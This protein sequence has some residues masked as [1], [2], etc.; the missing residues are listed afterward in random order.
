MEGHRLKTIVIA[1]L[2]VLNGFLLVLVGARKTE[3][4]RYE[5]SALERT[6][7]VLARNGIQTTEDAVMGRS[8]PSSVTAERD[9]AME[10]AVAAALLGEG[11]EGNNR[12]GGLYIYATERGQLSFRSGGE[13]AA[14]FSEDDFWRTDDPE[15]HA[16]QLMDSLK[17][18]CEQIRCDISEGSGQVVYRQ[19]LDGSPLY[20]CRLTFTYK[21]G[22][23]TALSGNLLATEAEKAENE[24]LLS[25]PTVLM[26]FLDDVLES[27]DVCSAILKVEPGYL[28]VQSFTEAMRLNPVWYISTNT[29]DY[30][31]DA[32][33]GQ[34]TRVTE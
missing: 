6:I 7:E 23:L 11:A 29:A 3:A 12:G 9:L 20:S 34:L 33:T 2:L 4:V 19:L 22:R 17:L 24:E 8:V 18:D 5:Q 21:Q 15:S 32:A 28:M 1:I 16:A 14:V 25:L 26:R 27:G 30:Y 31:V 10:G 13:L